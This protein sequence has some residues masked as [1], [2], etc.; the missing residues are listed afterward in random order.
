MDTFFEQIV[1]IRKTAREF[2]ILAG[3]WL[4]AGI[5]AFF[6]F[7]FL[8]R[9]GPIIALA[10]AGFI[11]YGAFKLSQRFF[12]EYEYIITNGTFDVD[13]I[14]AKSSRK[15][16]MS[17]DI[18]DISSIEKYN[19]AKPIPQGLERSLIACDKTD[20]SAYCLQASKEGKGRQFLAFSPNERIKEGIVKFLPKYMANSAF[21]D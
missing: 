6:G 16:V 1:P 18:A 12:I 14:I 3:I 19:P 15:R 2:L 9:F 8:L 17:F 13:K 5:V 4:A 10:A 11:F 7:I 21:K 20:G